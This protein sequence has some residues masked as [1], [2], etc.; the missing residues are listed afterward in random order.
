MIHRPPNENGKSKKK[1]MLD[2]IDCFRNDPY[3]SLTIL[4]LLSTMR[5]KRRKKAE[6]NLKKECE[7]ISSL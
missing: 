6:G 3:E 5:A 1:K 4:S 7:K 2:I